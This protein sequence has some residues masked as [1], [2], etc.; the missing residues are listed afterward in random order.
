MSLTAELWN[1]TCFRWPS[2]FVILMCFDYTCPWICRYRYCIICKG[3]GLVFMCMY[4]MY[5]PTLQLTHH[6]QS[7]DLKQHP[8]YSGRTLLNLFHPSFAC[9][10]CFGYFVL[11][12]G[13]TLVEYLSSWVWEDLPMFLLRSSTTPFS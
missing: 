1:Q 4:C 2:F 7:E 10:S 12:R 9:H 3:T 8:V 13:L 11:S 5:A 6:F